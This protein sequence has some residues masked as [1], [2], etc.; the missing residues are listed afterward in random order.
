M[1]F[2]DND[3]TNHVTVNCHI[4]KGH[5]HLDCNS[6]NV[7]IA[8][9][10]HTGAHHTT[11]NAIHSFPPAPSQGNVSPRNCIV[12]NNLLAQC[13][14]S[15]WKNTQWVSL[16]CTYM[17]NNMVSC[18]ITRFRLK[19]NKS[20]VLR[21][22]QWVAEKPRVR[23]SYFVRITRFPHMNNTFSYVNHTF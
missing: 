1:T 15:V 10:T 11:S 3:V 6:A 7:Q 22:T 19:Q 5:R 13:L 16:R 20:S 21:L 9:A 4:A 14:L 8:A 23:I 2:H 17:L 12:Q 18:P